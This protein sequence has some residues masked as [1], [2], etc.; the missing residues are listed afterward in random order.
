MARNSLERDPHLLI[1][2]SALLSAPIHSP[3]DCVTAKI[4]TGSG[5]A[6]LQSYLTSESLGQSVLVF[7]QSLMLGNNIKKNYHLSGTE[8]LT[9]SFL[10]RRRTQT[11]GHIYIQTYPTL[12][13]DDK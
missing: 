9:K 11:S 12:T 1:I 2:V 4:G 8:I 7:T 13:L 6:L 3:P 10:P 5:P